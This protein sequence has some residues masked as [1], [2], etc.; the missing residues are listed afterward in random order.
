[1]DFVIPDSDVSVVISPTSIASVTVQKAPQKT[2]EERNAEELKY[3]NEMG[4]TRSLGALLA[5]LL[6]DL[7]K[8]PLTRFAQDLRRD[9]AS[10]LPESAE[11]DPRAILRNATGPT[12]EYV[13][14]H[15]LQVVVDE[16]IKQMMVE[17]PTDIQSYCMSWLRWNCRNVI[18]T[19][20]E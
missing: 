15:K 4:V 19:L 9:I 7:P 8:D 14:K 20:E 10:T 2:A 11:A 13:A 5:K 16:M 1:M 3:L 6:C 18:G 12:A 17:R